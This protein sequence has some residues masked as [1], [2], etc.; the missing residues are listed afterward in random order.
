MQNSATARKQREEYEEAKKKA[1]IY[2]RFIAEMMFN[3]NNNKGTY[4]KDIWQWIIEHKVYKKSTDYGDF[5]RAIQMNIKDGWLI[6]TKNSL[7]HPSG[8][9]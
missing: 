6:N 9:Y 1:K 8:I 5:L 7:G 3:H 2:L 4:R